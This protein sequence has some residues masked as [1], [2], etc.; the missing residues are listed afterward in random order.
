MKKVS[1]V[2]SLVL[3][4]IGTIF[5]ALSIFYKEGYGS[6]WYLFIA[7]LSIT[8]ANFINFFRLRKN[9]SEKS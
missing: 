8:F 7:L 5:L 4:I 9:K 6:E 2:A 3:I 1:V